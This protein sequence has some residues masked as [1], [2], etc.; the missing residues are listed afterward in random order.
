MKDEERVPSAQ[1]HA[2]GNDET[3]VEIPP[4]DAGQELEKAEE[5]KENNG[6][7]E[8]EFE[9]LIKGKYASRFAQKVQKIIDKRFRQTKELEAQVKENNEFM[10]RLAVL[11]EGDSSKPDQLYRLV[12]ELAKREKRALPDPSR[13]QEMTQRARKDYPDF[14]PV[15]ALEEPEFRSL[16]E[17]GLDFSRAYTLTHL[18]GIKEQSLKEGARR[19]LL[20]VSTM[21][22]RPAEGELSHGTPS[23]RRGVASLSSSEVRNLMERAAKGEKI[24]FKDI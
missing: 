24:K 22:S 14:D 7:D 20:S 8:D 17:M 11:C 16:V 10:Q 18:E 1:L 3:G 15:K 12:E 13:M 19:A 4:A 2:E 9:Q 5:V 21:G 6:T 23:G